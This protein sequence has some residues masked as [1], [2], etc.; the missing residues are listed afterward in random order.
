MITS[1][2]AFGRYSGFGMKNGALRFPLCALA[3][4]ALCVFSSA[5]RAADRPDRFSV[6]DSQI[7]ALGIQTAPVQIQTDTVRANFPAQVVVPP[8]A[9][10]VVSSPVTGLVA[11]LLV[12]Q[13]QAVRRGEA[14]VRIASPELGQ[15][16]LQ[17]L[18]AAA[19][20]T[21]A[22]QTNQRE[23]R[24]LDEG[25]IPQR[26]VQ[27]AQ[28]AM[29][30]AQAA[31]DHARAALRLSGMP[32]E[33]IA[34]VAASGQPQDTITLT[35]TRAGIVSAIAVKPGQR[36]EPATALLHVSQ[37][38]T[39]WLEIQIP[40][41]E[42][43]NWQPGAKIGIKGKESAARL[44]SVSPTVSAGS[45]TVALRAVVEGKAAQVRP[46]E[47]VTV[48]LPAASAPGSWDLPLAAVAHDGKQAY[49]F[50]RMPGGFEA[51]PVKIR[52]GAGQRTSAEGPL[53]A[54]EQIAVSGVVALKGAWLE[55]KEPR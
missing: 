18:R 37:T 47:F 7:Q 9:E 50:V 34:R 15:L 45:Q 25:I 12:Q 32:A 20:A 27:E 23:Q 54:G 26:R 22:R 36:V 24:L 3:V 29:T 1:V 14:L 35:A 55:G 2:R 48:E 33:A 16:Q 30:E 46:G 41:A 4:A 8:N 39:L 6:P 51:R 5:T 43:L 44:L 42:S 11:Q 10:Q 38:D 40:V 13:N 21:L 31:L 49:V 28:A 52:A 17:L 19:R 53:K